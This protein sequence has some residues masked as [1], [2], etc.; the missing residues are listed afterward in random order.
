MQLS[1]KRFAGV[2]TEMMSIIKVFCALAFLTLIAIAPACGAE[3]DQN[4]LGLIQPGAVWLDTQGRPIQAHSGGILYHD[5]LWYWFGEDRTQGLDPDMRFVSCYSSADLLH[6][7]FRGRP[8]QLADPEQLGPNWVLERP[9]VFYSPTTHQFVMYF[10]LDDSPYKVARVG[11]AVSSSPTGPYHYL[12]SFRPLGQE[13][14]DIGQ[15]VDDDGSAYL[16][17]ESRPSGG[18]YIAQLSA[19]RLSITRQVA[20][21]HLPLEG[22]ALAHDGSQYYVLGSHLTGWAPNPNVY[23]SAPSLAGPWTEFLPIAPESTNNY[24]SQS[25]FLLKIKGK[26]KTTVVFLGDIWKPDA[27]WDSRYLWM[28]VQINRNK[29][30]L[31]PPVPWTID[32]TTGIVSINQQE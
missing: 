24:E 3:T 4:L 9:K 21:L 5:H 30:H 26:Q 18:F 22:G 31:P 7:T 1:K 13:S 23:A 14:R 20:F 8:L 6:W 19:D 11:I 10:H 27:L 15:F 32:V 17:F 28:P 16:I 12:R 29:M 25:T 2:N